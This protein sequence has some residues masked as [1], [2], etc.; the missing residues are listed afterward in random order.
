MPSVD[1]IPRYFLYG[2]VPSEVELLFLHVEAIPAR[3]GPHDWTIRAHAH[4]DHHQILL[5]TQGGGT[6]RLDENVL[7]FEAPALFVVPA[8]AV[9]AIE[10]H[11]NSDGFVITVSTNFLQ[12]AIEDDEDLAAA[13]ARRRHYVYNDIDP[14]SGL[15]D[16]FQSIAREFVWSAPGRRTAIK[17]HFQRILVGLTRLQNDAAS[18]GDHWHHRDTEIVVR[19]R[20]LIERDFRQQ[21]SLAGFAALLGVTTARLNQACRAIIG[22]TALTLLHDR[23]LIEAKRSL[24]YTG[25]TVAEIAWSMGFADPAYFN[26]FFSRRAGV[27]PGVFRNARGLGPETTT[28]PPLNGK[29]KRNPEK[30]I[31]HP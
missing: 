20:E 10:F 2:E 8:L 31:A 30:S 22:K 5:M 6:L 14:A 4:P 15:S 28:P 23:I 3:S 1:T 11:P 17:A 7:P 27:S 13:F 16:A 21:P 24:L 29:S 12:A 18:S 25:M 19:Y 26:R 9:H